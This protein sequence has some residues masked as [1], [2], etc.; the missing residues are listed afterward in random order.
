MADKDA[1]NSPQDAATQRQRQQEAR[2]RS[3]QQEYWRTNA[4]RIRGRNRLM[5]LAIGAFVVGICILH[6]AV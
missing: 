1:Q 5:G 2:S 4:E 3:L 6:K